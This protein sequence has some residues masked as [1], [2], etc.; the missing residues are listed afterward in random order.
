VVVEAAAMR[1]ETRGGHWREDFPESRDE[2]L[3]RISGRLEPDGRLRTA[4]AALGTT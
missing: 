1:E 4:F 3:G 2:W